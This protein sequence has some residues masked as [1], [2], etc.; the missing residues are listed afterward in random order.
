M[1][2]AL[3]YDGTFTRAPQLWAKVVNLIKDDGHDVFIVTNR[4]PDA[5]IQ[6]SGLNVIYTS[7]E[8]KGAYMAR[9]GVPVDIWIDDHPNRIFQ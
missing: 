1:R 5:E 3:D 2:I 9:C 4:Y 8:P 7:M 6:V